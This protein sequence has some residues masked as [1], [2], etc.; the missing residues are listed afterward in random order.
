MER[1]ELSKGQHDASSDE[2]CKT[3][4]LDRSTGSKNRDEVIQEERAGVRRIA[5]L[6]PTIVTIAALLATAIRQLLDGRSLRELG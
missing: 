3:S 1:R 4:R 2:C 5:P 6:T